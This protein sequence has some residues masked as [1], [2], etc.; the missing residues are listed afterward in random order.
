VVFLDAGQQEHRVVD[1]EPEGD[2][3]DAGGPN[4]VDVA[5]AAERIAGGH[6]ADEADDADRGRDRGEV[7]GNRQRCEERRPE[8][9]EQIAAGLS[10]GLSLAEI[11][12]RL[13]RPTSTVSRE[14]QRNGGHAGYRAQEAKDIIK[15]IAQSQSEPIPLKD[16]I[17]ETLKE[18]ARG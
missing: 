4:G 16:L 3:E 9:R 7:E 5:V 17:R 15:R 2:P 10:E 11:A 8:D 18:L 14:V 13:D 12:R 6:L 1:R